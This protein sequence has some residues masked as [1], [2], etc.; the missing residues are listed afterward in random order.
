[1][2]IR[3]RFAAIYPGTRKVGVSLW[4]VEDGRITH[5]AVSSVP[6]I[7]LS[8]ILERFCADVLYIE[9]LRTANTAAA[10]VKAFAER[11]LRFARPDWGNVPLSVL[12]GLPKRQ[13]R[14]AQ[15]AYRIGFS[16]IVR[17]GPYS[18]GEDFRA[19]ELTREWLEAHSPPRRRDA[20]T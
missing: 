6:I 3:E 16:E 5:L 17:R 12:A 11:G 2:A 15:N 7:A 14:L 1:M 20:T 18:I 10:K 9:S 19:S 8:G 4:L 13:G